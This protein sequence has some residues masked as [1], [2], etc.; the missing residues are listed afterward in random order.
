MGGGTFKHWDT[1][2]AK[3][4][5]R[6]DIRKFFFTERVI[7]HWNRL[8]REVVESPSLEV[9]KG[10]LDEVLRDMVLPSDPELSH[11]MVSE[12]QADV[13]LSQED[14]VDEALCRQI[15]AAS[16]SQ[17]LVFMGDF[18]HPDTC[19][20]DNAAGHKKS[21]RFLECTDDNFLLQMIEE[22]MRRGAMLNLVLIN[23]VG[24]VGGGK[25]KSSLGCCDHEIVEFNIL[26]ALRRVHSKLTTLDFR[27]ADFGLFRGLLGRVQWDKALEGRGAQEN[28]LIFK[29]VLLQA[30]E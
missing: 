12:A 7:K 25:L 27:R 23:K 10:R 5:F 26:R 30:Q 1:H 17:A 24:L 28:W 15:G 4:R 9:F 22:P 21:G 13:P 18:N 8:P 3:G 19:W 6:L 11:L 29:D 2:L 14:Q 20:R 16:G